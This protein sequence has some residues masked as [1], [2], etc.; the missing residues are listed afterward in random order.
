MAGIG[1]QAAKPKLQ[2]DLQKLLY[3][4]YL[5]PL[6]VDDKGIKKTSKRSKEMASTFAQNASG[7]MADAIMNFIT[8]AMITGTIQ[9]IVLGTCAVGPVSGS[10]TDILSGTELSLV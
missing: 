3:D 5:E 9:G 2:A 4:A 6:K 8:Q 10:N 7:P 1:L